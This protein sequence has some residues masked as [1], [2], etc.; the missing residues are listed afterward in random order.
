MFIFEMTLATK[1]Y[2]QFAFLFVH[3][4]GWREEVED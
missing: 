4:V 1:H 3:T 2:V